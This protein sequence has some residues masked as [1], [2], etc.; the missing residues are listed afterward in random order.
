MIALAYIDYFKGTDIILFLLSATLFLLGIFQVITNKLKIKNIGGRIWGGVLI[1]S[2]IFIL[3]LYLGNTFS[4]LITVGYFND[5]EMATKIKYEIFESQDKE[6]MLETIKEILINRT[7]QLIEDYNKVT[8]ENINIYYGDGDYSESI[9]QI[10]RVLDIEYKPLLKYFKEFK[11]KEVNVIV[12]DSIDDIDSFVG[13]NTMAYYHPITNIITTMP[14]NNFSS[15]EQFKSVIFHEYTHYALNK[16]FK[17]V[18]GRDNIKIPRWFDE[19]LATYFEEK[20]YSIVYE[21]ISTSKDIGDITKDYNFKGKKAYDYY[22]SSKYMIKYM[23]E[24]G[25]STFIS[26]LLNDM[27]NTNDIYESIENILGESFNEIQGKVLI[28]FSEGNLE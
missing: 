4:K 2:L 1:S 15:I 25:G 11:D 8:Y 13:E 3:P 14:I 18:L 22:Q 7:E 17:A 20:Y 16:E 24:K 27:A 6:E 12:V 5:R 21:D 23:I 10:K 19:G 28:N 26:D 9:K